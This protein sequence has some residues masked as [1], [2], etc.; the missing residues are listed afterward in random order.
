[1]G[2]KITRSSIASINNKNGG[3]NAST[4]MQEFLSY[5]FLHDRNVGGKNKLFEACM[6]AVVQYRFGGVTITIKLSL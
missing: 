6:S 4:N 2:R 3:K 5:D 1:M